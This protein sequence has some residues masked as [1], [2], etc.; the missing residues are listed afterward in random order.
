MLLDSEGIDAIT[1]ND[2]GDKQIFTLTVLLASAFIYN[3][4]GVPTK[5]DL[6]RLQYPLKYFENYRS[7]VLAGFFSLNKKHKH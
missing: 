7:N 1:G 3:S 6:Q 2:L 5:S 4:E